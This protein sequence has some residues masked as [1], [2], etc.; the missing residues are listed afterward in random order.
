MFKFIRF[1]ITHGIALAIGFA[2]GIYLLPVLIAPEAP[3]DAAVSSSASEAIYRARFYRDLPGSDFL[4]WGDGEVA[5]TD[6]QISFMGSIAPGPDYQ[7]YLTRELALTEQEFLA[8]K[9][10]S[11]RV[12]A[13]RTFDNFILDIPATIRPAEYRA[14]VVWCETFGEFITAAGYR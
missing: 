2:L 1:L 14:L 13:I 6:K 12:G 5:I 3:S 11:A 4:H 9:N 7:L 8:I 10:E